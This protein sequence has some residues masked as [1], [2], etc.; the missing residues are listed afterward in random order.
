[1]ARYLV[2]ALVETE[3]QLTTVEDHARLA[4]VSELAFRDTGKV[5]L[6]VLSGIAGRNI[7]EPEDLWD[8][9]YDL[10]EEIDKI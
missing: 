3:L 4:L 9:V 6:E 1:M 10:E 8:S 5:V 2:L 7:D